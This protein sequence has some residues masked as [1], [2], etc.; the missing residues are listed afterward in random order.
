MSRRE[1]PKVASTGAKRKRATDALVSKPPQDPFPLEKV[2]IKPPSDDEEGNGGHNEVEGDLNNDGK[3]DDDDDLVIPQIVEGSDN[4]DSDAEGEE[5]V[6]EDEDKR[7]E[8][9]SDVSS[10]L[11]EDSANELE[12][13]DEDSDS[14]DEVEVGS[15]GKTIV[16][17]ITGRPKRVY[18]H[19]EAGYDSDS[20]TEDDPNRIG[21]VPMHWYDDLPHIGYDLDGKKIFRPAKGDELD[22]FLSTVEDPTSWTAGFDRSTQN[23]IQLTTEELDIIR[24]LQ[25]GENPDAGY[26]P[27][28][29]MVEWYSGKGKEMVLPVNRRPEPKRRWLPSKWEKQKVMKIVRAIREGRIVPNKPVSKE[30]EFYQ[31][32]SDSKRH[33]PPPLAA[34]KVPLPTNAESYNPPAEYLPSTEEKAKWEATGT[35]NSG[36]NFLPQKY[37]ALRHVPGYD[38]FFQERFSRL[39]D[40]YM[41]PRV[42]RKRRK[43]KIE[44]K[45]LLPNLPS[46]QELKPFPTFELLR[47]SHSSRARC[48][49]ISPDG[50]WVASGDERG[51]VRI[52]ETVVG[53]KGARFK[54]GSRVASIAWCP[55]NGISFLVVGIDEAIH[56]IMPPYQPPAIA[57]ATLS[58][59]TPPN[60]PHPAQE[61]LHWTVSDSGYS[62]GVHEPIMTITMPH[63]S[64]LV[65]QL[66]FHRKGDY[67]ASTSASGVVW[68][69]Q[70]SKRHSQAP[71][72][73]VKG[74]VQKVLFHPIRPQFFVATQ[75][76]IRLYDLVAQKLLRTLSST[77]RWISSMDVHPS[78]DHLI[79]GSYD[80]KLAW[81]DLEL[82]EKPYKILKFHSKAIR[83]VKFHPSYPLFASSSDDGT[84]QIFHGRVYND[85]TTDPLIVP[86]RV[87][88]GHK[89]SDHLGVLEIEWL[90][91]HP[92][93]VSAGA[94]GNVAV[95]AN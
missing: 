44:A 57:Q 81:F 88:S 1:A 26:N 41:A 90:R 61:S 4:S 85:L 13:K 56:F 94:D 12:E 14:E 38:R 11:I 77:M 46:P 23:D 2:D 37:D 66:T 45:S 34:P 58:V 31:I 20:S 62:Q 65:K 29:P 53:H 80:S 47:T 64:G 55:Q 79:V 83:S 95:W 84:I 27:Y 39:L 91:D 69:H 75:R 73:R 78:G 52:W 40:L 92:W 54:F 32:W 76:Y 30:P 8:E 24:R 21:N 48:I 63:A 72:R 19:I 67:V 7:D 6:E 74:V 60:L 43:K 89:I 70:I 87:L 25:M 36:R 22:K 71:F 35:L 18:P 15:K 68:I 42:Q 28:E 93:L 33:Q 59:L 9:E 10:F 51:E 5:D 86:L 50:V 49:S 17:D 16:S 82:G 3:E